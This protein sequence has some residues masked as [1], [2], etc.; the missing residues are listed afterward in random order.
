MDQPPKPQT[1][2]PKAWHDRVAEL[3]QLLRDCK[4]D[5][6]VIENDAGQAFCERCGARVT[7]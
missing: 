2:L 6:R 4:H 3:R 5:G 7:G 1:E